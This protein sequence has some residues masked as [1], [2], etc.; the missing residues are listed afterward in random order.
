MTNLLIKLRISFLVLLLV[1]ASNISQAEK[2][3]RI[4]VDSLP[5]YLGHP[6]GSTARPTS[7]TNSAIFDGLIQFD[8]EGNIFPRLALQWENID[9]KT[10]R[11]TLRNNVFL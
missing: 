11:F 10:W 7:F 4:A 9:T 6:F 8:K 5:P 2:K 3:L 1:M